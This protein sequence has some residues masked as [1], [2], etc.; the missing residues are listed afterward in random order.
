MSEVSADA[1]RTRWL[2]SW[3]LHLDTKT[4]ADARRYIDRVL[5]R[6]GLQLS[7]DAVELRGARPGTRGRGHQRL[8]GPLAEAVL[9][10]LRLADRLGMSWDM[11]APEEW[12]SGAAEFGGWCAKPRHIELSAIEFSLSNR[13]VSFPSDLEVS[14]RTKS[15]TAETMPEKL[16]SAH[17]T[18]EG[19]W[20]RVVVEAGTILFTDCRF[21]DAPFNVVGSWDLI[22][23]QVEHFVTPNPDTV[24]HVELLRRKKN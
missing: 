22:E 2:L 23:P 12:G 24:F 16:G 8:E 3:T 21:P 1:W 9:Q 10:T 14:R 6:V 20:G 17:T 7:I 11:R 18:A 4:V 13:R 15:F 5:E 19:V